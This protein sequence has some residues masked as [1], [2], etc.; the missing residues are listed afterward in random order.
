LFIGGGVIGERIAY[1]GVRYKK[2]SSLT[3]DSSGAPCSTK[4]GI[5]S[6][7]ARGIHHGAGKDVRADAGAFFD[8]GDLDIAQFMSLVSARGFLMLLSRDGRG[9]ARR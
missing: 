6:L 7:S 9:A 1:F 3:G 4:S 8:D 2:K 5:S